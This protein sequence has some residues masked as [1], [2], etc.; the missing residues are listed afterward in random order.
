MI[1]HTDFSSEMKHA[2]VFLFCFFL[3]KGVGCLESEEDGERKKKRKCT[4][5]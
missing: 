1:L 4:L 2:T 5:K 3:V